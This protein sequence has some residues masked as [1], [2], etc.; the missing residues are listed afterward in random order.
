M[1]FVLYEFNLVKTGN[2]YVGTL[3]NSEDTDEMQQNVAFHHF[4]HR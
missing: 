1:W 2:P 4:L 3:T